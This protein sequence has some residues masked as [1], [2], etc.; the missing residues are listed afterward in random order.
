M[1]R[2]NPDAE[3][4]S[5]Q[6]LLWQKQGFSIQEARAYTVEGFTLDE[7]LVI[8]QYGLTIDEVVGLLQDGIELDEDYT[9]TA[10][11]LTPSSTTWLSLDSSTSTITTP[12]LEH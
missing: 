9:D 4:S 2:R 6:A 11:Y 8:R 5:T 3:V 1:I 7:A 10:L 12:K